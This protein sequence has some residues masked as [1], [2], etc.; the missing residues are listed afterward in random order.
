MK[1]LI[2]IFIFLFSYF[3]GLTQSPYFPYYGNL[4]SHT[5]ISDGVG[6]PE[7]AFN[8]ARDSA[9]L[10]FLAVTDHLEQIYLDLLGWYETNN[11]A[12]DATVN[13]VFVGF[14]GY[15]WG[16]PQYGHCNVLNAE[17][18]GDPTTYTDLSG[19]YQDVLDDS[20]AFGF[21]NH[22]AEEVYFS[23]WDNFSYAGA[24]VDAAFPLIEM[25]EIYQEQWYYTALNNGWHVSPVM[26]QDNHSA[27]WGTKND[28]RAGIW[29]TDLS[30]QSLIDAMMAGRTFASWDKNAEMWIDIGGQAM[31]QTLQRYADMPLHI[32]INDTEQW[33][34][35]DIIDSTGIIN[36][37]VPSG[38]TVD[39]I[40]NITPSVSDWVIVRACQADSQLIW[41]APIYFNGIITQT[42]NYYSGFTS[43]VYPNPSNG[44]FTI[45]APSNI[46]KIEIADLNGNIIFTR[47]FK[48]GKATVINIEGTA[49]GVY[50]IKIYSKDFVKARK[51]VIY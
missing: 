8:L 49:S 23:N 13:N 35:V 15:E 42:T 11:A 37:F 40:I 5:S 27:D 50:F 28:N 10:D 20:P 43:Y 3:W 7:D 25:Q 19:F 12:D 4:H 39:T 33:L 9:H 36:T 34:S 38:N 44:P 46:S 22:P 32:F 1:S 2:F 29:A 30:R 18:M 14:A 31:G 6:S 48:N 47:L 16:S 21:F 51:L 45:E 24:A 41:S 17:N 26:N